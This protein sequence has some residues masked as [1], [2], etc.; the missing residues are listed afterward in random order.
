VP[1]TLWVTGGGG[2]G[3]ASLAHLEKFNASGCGLGGVLPDW[4]AP[5]V[6]PP[7]QDARLSELILSHNPR[8]SGAPPAPM[9]ARPGAWRRSSCGLLC[10][11]VRPEGRVCRGLQPRSEGEMGV[12]AGARCACGH[13]CRWA[14]T[15]RLR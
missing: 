2:G 12:R 5:G 7:G 13:R 10:A 11:L 6:L 1:R 14:G 4:D 15:R 9:R 8:L 3:A